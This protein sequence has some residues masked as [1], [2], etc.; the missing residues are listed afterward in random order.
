VLSALEDVENSIVSLAQERIRIQSLSKA[1]QR[2]REAA[3][4]SRS[5]YETGSSSFLDVLD[6]ERS[7]YTA[8]DSLLQSRVAIATDYIALSKALGGG[9]DGAIDSSRPDV[10]DV[11]TGPHIPVSQ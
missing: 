10:N 7:L 2:Y 6:A 4:L 8:E 3:R 1:A 11:S 5:L 9:W